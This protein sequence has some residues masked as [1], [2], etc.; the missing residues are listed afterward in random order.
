MAFPGPDRGE[1]EARFERAAPLR[2]AFSQLPAFALPELSLWTTAGWLYIFQPLRFRTE[3]DC[4][5]GDHYANQSKGDANRQNKTAELR[6]MQ[7]IESLP[8]S[9]A[10]PRHRVDRFHSRGG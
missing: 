3:G 4:G 1:R 7:P 10:R 6:T 9:E 2:P 5:V 8:E